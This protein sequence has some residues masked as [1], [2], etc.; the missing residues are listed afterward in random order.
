[1]DRNDRQRKAELAIGKLLALG[2][3]RE[4][5]TLEQLDQPPPHT[6]E[7]WVDIERA[8]RKR[9]EDPAPY[10]NLAREYMAACP[11]EWNEILRESVEKETLDHLPTAQEI[12]AAAM[13]S[14]VA[15]SR[16]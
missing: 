15:Q 3:L 8:A 16:F 7:M 4:L 9:G 5:W 1:M 11:A 12:V 10:R 6:R 14:P 13:G 2:T